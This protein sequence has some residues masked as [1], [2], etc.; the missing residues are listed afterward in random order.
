MCGIVGYVG[1]REAAGVLLDGLSRL[2]YRGYDSAGL[3]VAHRRK[4]TVRR[5]AGRV[6]D[7]RTLLGDAPPPG[8]SGVAHT[9]W[10]THGEPSEANAHPHTDASGRVAIVH[11]GIVENAEALRAALTARGVVLRSDTDSEA[12]A[13]LVAEALAGGAA[14]LADAVR[15]ALAGVEGTYGLA[16]LD[17]R[18]PDEIVVA[19]N[20]SPIVLGIGDGEM[21]VASDLAAVVRHT[22]KVV[23]LDDGE[24]V[25][26]R[27]DGI[28]GSTR[29]SPTTVDTG[30][31]DYA[32][33]DLLGQEVR[34]AA[35]QPDA[36]RRA[37]A[38]GGRV[39]GGQRCRGRAEDHQC[40]HQGGGPQAARDCRSAHRR[41]SDHPHPVRRQAGAPQ[42]Q[43]QARAGQRRHHQ[44]HREQPRCTSAVQAEPVHQHHAAG[45]LYRA[46]GAAHAQRDQRLAAA[47][48]ARLAWLGGSGWRCGAV[49]CGPAARQR[50]AGA[51]ARQRQQRQRCQG[52][53]RHQ[54]SGGAKAQ[55]A[56]EILRHAQPRKAAEPCARVG[57]RRRGRLHQR[58]HAAGAQAMQQPGDEQAGQHPGRVQAVRRCQ[59]H[60]AEHPMRH[61]QAGECQAQRLQCAVAVAGPAPQRC[62]QGERRGAGGDDQT[63]RTEAE[64]R[65]LDQ[66]RHQADEHRLREAEAGPGGGQRKV[67]RALR[68]A[69]VHGWCSPAGGILLL[70]IIMQSI[71]IC[72]N[73]G[74]PC[75]VESAAKSFP[76]VLRHVPA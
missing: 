23:F 68:R 17:A 14:T 28:E 60:R 69:A 5:T 56:G 9:R 29:I 40:R 6:E 57:E 75:L 11:N 63:E 31:E 44:R 59:H 26:V 53:Q 27:A 18:T 50:E 52:R 42:S 10:A 20:G 7:L 76:Y 43:L 24:I 65:G 8:R 51:E 37:Q 13:H 62:A 25:T 4:V 45:V 36:L 72:I 19:R 39:G 66:H 30:S 48:E 21:V 49:A 16:V 3:A 67:A 22:R 38:G 61:H 35:E 2:E 64:A 70:T 47:Q 55:Q 54:R 46:Q 12:L 1:P 71:L 58:Y 15:T 73:G 74:F 32:L 41:R 33:G 34:V